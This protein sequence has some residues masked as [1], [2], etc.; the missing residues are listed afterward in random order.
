MTNGNLNNSPYISGTITLPQQHHQQVVHGRQQVGMSPVL[1]S[2]PL[3]QG[4]LNMPSGVAHPR[5]VQS[6]IPIP[7]V[8]PSASSG[9]RSPTTRDTST[10]AQIARTQQFLGRESTRSISPGIPPATVDLS[11]ASN[12]NK[13]AHEL[14]TLV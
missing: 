13:S 1:S 3:A 4:H 6:Q 12:A 10:V 5:A 2:A 11:T 14:S 8:T 9:D 7:P